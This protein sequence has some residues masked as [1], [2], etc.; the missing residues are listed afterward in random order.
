MPEDNHDLA[1]DALYRENRASQLID[2]VHENGDWLLAGTFTWG[3]VGY[4]LTG[5]RNYPL[6]AQWHSDWRQREDARPWML[7]NAVEAFRHTARDLEALEIGLKITEMPDA[8]GQ[9]LNFLWLAA[10]AV[11]SGDFQKAA[12]YLAA[13]GIEPLDE[14]YQFLDSCIR[15]VVDMYQAEPDELDEVFRESRALL[16]M[17]LR[18]YKWLDKEPA[19]KKAYLTAVTQLGRLRGTLLARLW[20]WWTRL[21]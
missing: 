9:N 20:A 15:A 3:A 17:A 12:E 21:G 7:V 18:D 2:Y 1:L 19:R 14:D 5:I 13:A 10:S 16:A 6:A 4:A 8:Q 11:E